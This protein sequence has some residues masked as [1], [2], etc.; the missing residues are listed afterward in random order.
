MV[1]VKEKEH[2]RNARFGNTVW[3]QKRP[4]TMVTGVVNMLLSS[5]STGLREE[6]A[7]VSNRVFNTPN[8]SGESRCICEATYKTYACRCASTRRV[9]LCN[10]LNML[11]HLLLGNHGKY[12]VG[13]LS[14]QSLPL[15]LILFVTLLQHEDEHLQHLRDT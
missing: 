9:L 7:T 3:Y 5:M 8:A 15:V 1:P 11:S 10:G 12:D 6:G 2:V 14:G 4:L 13:N